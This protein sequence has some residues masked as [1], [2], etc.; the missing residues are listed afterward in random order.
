MEGSHVDYETLV[1]VPKLISYKNILQN[2]ND[3]SAN[4][5]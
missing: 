3:H 2:S 4:P 5:Y 1:Q